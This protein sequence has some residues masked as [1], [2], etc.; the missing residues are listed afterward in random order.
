MENL[1][2]NN[3][4]NIIKPFLDLNLFFLV[5][6]IIFFGLLA[7]TS[8][9][10]EFS[11]K[12][13]EGAS[14]YLLF[15]QLAYLVFSIIVCVIFIN[16]NSDSL[17]KNYKVFLLFFLFLLLLVYLFGTTVGGSTRWLRFGFLNIQPSEFYKLFYI[18]W[19]CAYIDINKKRI[20]DIKIFFIPFIW[21]SIGAL[22]LLSQPDFGTIFI[23]FLMTILM[24]FIARAKF[25]HLFFVGTIGTLSAALIIYLHPYMQ[26]RLAFFDPCQNATQEGYQLCYSLMAIGSGSIF[27]KGLGA[28]TSKLH[29]LPE[30]HTD[31]IFAVIGEELGIFGILFLVFLFYLLYKKCFLL[32]D[33]ALRVN[34]NFQ[35]MLAYAI[36]LYLII[37][38]LLN[39]SV[40]L[41]LVPTKGMALPFFS[42]GGSNYLA[43]LL[44]ITII[45]RIYRDVYKKTVNSS[46][47]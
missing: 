45:F 29:F 1:K 27:G 12:E 3:I 19:L 16:I 43:S 32:G 4:N 7:L 37:Q 31:F 46:I 2:K 36:G 25:I 13:F 14:F 15:R 38:V 34:L 9:S 23:L 40:N 41:G 35:G 17:K 39:L 44:A 5:I 24:L 11:A 21:F 47:R 26:K 18:I 30:V 10:I 22:L 6:T 33:K 28:S 8:A 20:R 42:Y